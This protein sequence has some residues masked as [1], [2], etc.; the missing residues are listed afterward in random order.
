[1][2]YRTGQDADWHT[3]KTINI[4]RTGILFRSGD[5][6]RQDTAVDIRVHFPLRRT[7]FCQ[8]TIVRTQK[9]EYAV[10]IYHCQFKQLP[11]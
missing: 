1:M 3:C 8:G 4:S 11:E 5:L 9:S 10:R 2:H 6:L 7:L